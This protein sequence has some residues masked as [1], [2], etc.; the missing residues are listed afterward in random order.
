MNP[1]LIEAYEDEE[2]RR[3]QR[4]E[5]KIAIVGTAP[6]SLP[7]APWED[8]SWEVWG[9]SNSAPQL[10]R[11]D[12]WIECHTAEYL[13]E[14]GDRQQ[15]IQWLQQDHGEGKVI[16][17]NEQMAHAIP[18]GVPYPLDVMKDTFPSH[19]FTNSISYLLALAIYQQVDRIGVWGVD[20]SLSGEYADQRPSCEYFIGLARGKGIPV[21]V[22]PQA[23]LLKTRRLYGFEEGDGF[24]VSLEAREREL[25][26]QIQRAQQ[27]MEQLKQKIA[28]F[29]GAKDQVGWD[30]QNHLHADRLEEVG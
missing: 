1:D 30:M 19:Y 27:Q 25:N 15:H 17:A 8:E 20:M 4:P 18:N 10:P 6:A 5:R 14:R 21:H 24:Q 11:W 26:Q 9:T 7:Y 16:Y 28:T 12:V 13:V 2:A 23:D 3:S 22:P 29:K